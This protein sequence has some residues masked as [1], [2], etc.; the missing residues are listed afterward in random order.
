MHE[1]ELVSVVVPTRDV[2][3]TI[4]RCLNS[5]RAQTHPAIELIVVDNFSQ[6]GTWETARRLADVAVQAGPERATQRNLG[7]ERARGEWVLWIDADMELPPEAAE[8]AL[9]AAHAASA[10]GV[11][12]PEATIGNGFWTSCRALERRC[13]HG[14]PRIEA[15]R[16]L[17]TGYLR[18]LGGFNEQLAGTEDAELRTRMLADGASLAWADTLIVH[19]EGRLTLA[20]VARKRFYY[21]KGILTYRHAHPGAVSG[22]LGATVG[23][24]WRHRRLLA[25]DPPHAAGVLLLRAWEAAA[26]VAGAAAGALTSAKPRPAG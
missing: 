7:I 17:R 14:E 3:G 23:A 6:D 16:L 24:F 11:F 18:D 1:D 12:I 5:I 15:P 9:A 4:E 20:G 2:G 26:Y 19:H 25:A 21:G 8:R 10:V 22:Q 13:Y